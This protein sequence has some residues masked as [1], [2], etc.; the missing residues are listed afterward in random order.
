MAVSHVGFCFHFSRAACLQL[1]TER[2]PSHGGGRSGDAA[3]QPPCRA[4]PGHLL[5]Y[6]IRR[7]GLLPRRFPDPP[8]G[9]AGTPRVPP[10][11]PTLSYLSRRALR[12]SCAAAFG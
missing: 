2:D 12:R 1:C 8:P 6:P 10:P 7:T 11:A 5:V 9:R 4:I 3:D